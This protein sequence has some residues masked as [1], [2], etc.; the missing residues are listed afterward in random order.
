[1]S[2]TNQRRKSNKKNVKHITAHLWCKKYKYF[3][4]IKFLSWL[5]NVL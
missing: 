3:I 1:M 5:R 2:Q 4:F